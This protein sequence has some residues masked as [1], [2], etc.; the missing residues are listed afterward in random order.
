MAN[1]SNVTTV[2]NT[3][4][5]TMFFSFLGKNGASLASGADKDIP[6]SLWDMW[7]DD[8]IQTA[9]LKYALDNNLIEI[10]RTPAVLAYDDT[11]GVVYALGFDNGSPVA[12]DPDYGS[13]SGSAPST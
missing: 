5:S 8:T 2:R 9:A 3:S 12:V 7:A 13:Y 11:D 4:G 6:G 10:L 1:K